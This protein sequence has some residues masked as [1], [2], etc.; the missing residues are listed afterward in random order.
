M[1]LAAAWS[2]ATPCDAVANT[3]TSPAAPSMTPAAPPHTPQSAHA[4]WACPPRTPCNA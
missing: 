3:S 1:H 2:G 4:C